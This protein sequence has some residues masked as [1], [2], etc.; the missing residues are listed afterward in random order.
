MKLE[1]VFAKLGAG[2]APLR[3]DGDSLQEIV[4]PGLVEALLQDLDALLDVTQLLTVALDLVLDVGELAGRVHLQLLQHGLLTL[5]QEA[6][7]ALESVAD[8][9]PQTLGGGLK[10]RG[11]G[12]FTGLTGITALRHNHS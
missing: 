5:A 7:E 12:G 6:V 10:Q 2:E 3:C 1:M 8:G 4:P 9:C 11:R